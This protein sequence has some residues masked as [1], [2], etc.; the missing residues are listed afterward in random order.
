MSEPAAIRNTGA[1]FAAFVT[2]Y[3]DAALVEIYPRPT[4]YEIDFAHPAASY[5]TASKGAAASARREIR[6]LSN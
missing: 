6:K 2:R 4:R 5:E 3:G 1:K